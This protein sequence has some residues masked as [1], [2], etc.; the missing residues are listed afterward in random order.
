MRVSTWGQI[1]SGLLVSVLLGCG[2]GHGGYGSMMPAPTVSFSQPAAAATINFGQALTVTWTSA[3][4]TSCTATTSSA[5][6]GTF[7][8]TQMV[9]GSQTVVPTAAGTYTYTLNCTGSGGTKSAS[10]NVTVTPN[11]LAALAPTGAIPTVGS[12]IDPT[13]GDL[14]PYGLVVAP[15]TAGLITKGD[16]VVCNFNDGPTNTQGKGTTII[17]LH[18]AAGSKPYRIAQSADL[19]GCNALTMLPD[20]SIS[21]AAWGPNLNPLVS[22]SGAVGTPFSDTFSGPWGEAFVAATATQPAAI[23]VSNAPG[24]ATNAGGTIDR[25]SLD[26]DAQTSFTEI[27]TGICSGGAP[28]SIFGPA[29]LTYDPASDTLYVVATSSASVIAI[30]KVSSIP[31]DGVVVNGQCTGTTATPTP[32]PTFSGPSMASATVIAHG[33]PFNTPLS[34][35]LLKNGDLLVA[36]AD[37]GIG[38]ASATTN[39]LIEISPVLPG[40]FVGQPLQVDTGAPGALFGLAATVDAQGNQVIYFNDDNNYAVMQLGP[41]AGTGSG[42]G[43]Y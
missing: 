22:A 11:L 20:D 4:T 28:G 2:G 38:T 27:V 35:A 1:T 8:G 30:A 34:A 24:G 36:N 41:V 25:I 7:T 21:A 39:M 32:V 5:A 15:A 29:G 40:G 14:N 43:P 10:A 3:Y 17:G 18:P 37:I 16:L 13:N 26:V 9:S 19:L 33:A 31:K 23:Y 42:P 12:T 6:G